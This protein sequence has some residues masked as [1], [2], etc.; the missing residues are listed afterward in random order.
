MYRKLVIFVPFALLLMAGCNLSDLPAPALT[1]TPDS[2]SPL[3]SRTLPPKETAAPSFPQATEKPVESEVPVEP[4]E[5]LSSEGP[6]WV[7]HT[8][9]NLWAVNADGSGLT[10]LTDPN[11]L[12]PAPRTYRLSPSPKG[13]WLAFI[14]IETGD[15]PAPPELKIVHLPDLQVVSVARL[16]PDTPMD[17]DDPDAYDRWQAAGTAN[18]LAWSPDGTRLA[19]NAVIDGKS[20]DLYV[21]DI[22]SQSLIRLTDGPTES[23]FPAWSPDSRWVVHGA[24]WRLNLQSSGAGY[25][26]AGIW[27]AKA[28]ASDVALLFET[29][30]TGFERVIGWL[31]NSTVLMDTATPNEN[32]SCP[33]RD[34]RS[35]NLDTRESQVIFHGPYA[36][37]AFS[38][39]DMVVLLSVTGASGC[40]QN[41]SPGVYLLDLASGQPPQPVVED[42]A[43]EATWSDEARLFFVSTDFGVL[44]VST[45]GQF[46]DLLQP[47]GISGLP[48]AAFGSRRLAWSG[49]SLWIGTLQDNLESPPQKIYPFRVFKASWSPDGQYLLFSDGTNLYAASEPDFEPQQ[50]ANTGVNAPVWL[51]PGS[52]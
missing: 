28:D 32:L 50:R 42:T 33:Y 1:E 43:R 44:A 38:P 7:F 20:G 12:S 46:I 9:M 19:F 49:E 5:A 34:L 52:D 27:A 16:H 37:S 6:W 11:T 22:V 13:G 35:I 29:Q 15:S 48:I 21:Y 18:T 25:D 26:Y 36:V 31:G 3:P 10:P 47:E 51:L 4:P 24:V 45:S 40:E 41:L 14:E 17:R 30:I 23:V 8:T 39:E 2:A